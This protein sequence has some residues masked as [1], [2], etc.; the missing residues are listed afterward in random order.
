MSLKPVLIHETTSTT[1]VA[2][3][4]PE[5]FEKYK[6]VALNIE[7][8][9]G[10]IFGTTLVPTP[11]ALQH[12]TPGQNMQNFTNNGSVLFSIFAYIADNKIYARVNQ[13][14]CIATVYLYP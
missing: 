5:D 6:Y 11:V 13:N 10:L 1:F 12:N 7:V 9:S 14:N 2:K 8:S 3:D 4:L